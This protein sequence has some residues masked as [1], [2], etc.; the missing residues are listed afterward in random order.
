MRPKIFV[1]RKLPAPVEE[2]LRRDYDASLNI[3]DRPYTAEEIVAG[4]Q[5]AQAL[6]VTLTDRVDA[7]LLARLPET[8]RV[9]ATFSVGTNHLDI[10]AARARGLAVTNTPGAVTDATVEIAA[11]CLLG[12]ARRAAEGERVM[13]EGSWPGWSP[14]YLLGTQLTG[15]RLGIVGMG[16]IGQGLAQV[17]RALGMQV[18]YHNRRRLPPESE[19]GAVYHER[20]DEMLPLAQA[21][22][23]NCPATAENRHLLNA[24][25]LGL[26]PWGAVVVNTARGDL[27]DDDALL[28][29][30]RS[31]QVAAAGLDV[32]E[33]EP[34]VNPGY[35]ALP[36]VFLLPHLGTAT[37]EARTAMG[38]MAADN[39]DA[40]LAGKAPPNPVG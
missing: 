9:V 39:I 36:N 11:L 8:M 21:L 35:R 30:L 12:A 29:A 14:T 33:N 18:H 27:V 34:T 22:S 13:R 38:M 6:L 10:P 19:R 37:L 32:F 15:K 40:V 20:L 3:D 24:R 4:C 5:G 16:R 1:T 17:A 31:G 23:L 28:D 7:A 2:R 26:L 25:T